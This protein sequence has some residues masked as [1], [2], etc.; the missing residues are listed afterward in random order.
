M[1]SADNE[2]GPNL[3]YIGTDE[4]GKGDYFGPLVIAAVW[5]DEETQTLLKELGVRD[6]KTLSD[7]KCQQ[8]AGLI[9][10]ICQGR[11]R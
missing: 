5:L 6:S 11:C 3:P 4:S 2:S 7:R 1:S 8:L 9:R 10:K